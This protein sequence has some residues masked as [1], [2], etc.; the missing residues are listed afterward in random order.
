VL[1]RTETA[2]LAG[3]AALA[4]LAIDMYLPAMPPLARDL[5]VSFETAG[6]SIA[7]FLFGV[8]GGQL[9]SGPLSDRLGRRP[10]FLTGLAL[11]ALASVVAATTGEFAL[12]LLARLAQ[13]LGACS[14]MVS[15]RAIVRDRL[16]AT[17]SARFFSLLALIGGLAPVL[18]PMLGAGVIHFASWRA[19]FGVMAVFGVVLLGGATLGMGE[20][21]SA[22]TAAKARQE[23]PFAAYNALLRQRALL[24]YLLAAM[25]NS[26]GFFAYVANSSLVLV[27]HYALS[28]AGFSVVFG[29][30]SVALV[31]AS[32][33]NRALLRKHS[34]AALLAASGR[35]ALIMAAL[36][37]AFAATGI[38]GL[39]V[40][41]VLLFVMVGSVS[42]VQSNTM[43]GGLA[44][45]PL[46][47]GSAAALFGAATFAA[48][49]L[50]SWC[51]GMLSDGSASALCIVIATCLV[52]AALSIRLLVTPSAAA[53][54]PQPAA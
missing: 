20:S 1:K 32:Q 9:V 15:G 18:A 47:A 22:E 43:A 45:D 27:G 33:L 10:V 16:D 19:I 14:V 52:G 42:P 53:A 29:I 7:V 30:N 54:P 2:L 35:N 17:E 26:A 50:A 48:G 49:A 8:A 40:L 21:R 38:G 46:R 37:T 23:R 6:Q 3:F 41:S 25:F 51:V 5:G 44:V 24:G 11:F 28:P 39:P 31:G 36:F 4:P 34:I 12:L 13:A